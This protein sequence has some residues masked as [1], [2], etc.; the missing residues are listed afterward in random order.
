MSQA[1]LLLAITAVAFLEAA[2]PLSF[3]APGEVLIVAAGAALGPNPLVLGASGVAVALGAFLG[4]LSLYLVTRAV[5]SG[6]WPRLARALERALPA[7]GRLARLTRRRSAWLL[8][9]GRFVAVGRA[10]IPLLAARASI[11]LAPFALWTG[12]STLLWSA[13]L[14]GL[15]ASLGRG[16]EA[17]FPRELGWAISLAVVA[18]VLV[19]LAVLRSRRRRA[20]DALPD[21]QGRSGA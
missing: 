20:A 19:A 11:P 15:G 2:G 12:V 5:G 1:I 9:A 18:I 7:D 16:A 14:L 21:S 4:S 3:L 13:W 8:V 10:A 6:R 17:L